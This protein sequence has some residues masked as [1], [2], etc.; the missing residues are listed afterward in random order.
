MTPYPSVDRKNR[1]TNRLVGHAIKNY[2]IHGIPVQ[3]CQEA[4]TAQQ[5]HHTYRCQYFGGQPQQCRT[6][7]ERLIVTART[8]YDT[9][10]PY[11]RIYAYIQLRATIRTIRQHCCCSGTNG[12][13]TTTAIQ[14]NE[15]PAWLHL[16]PTEHIILMIRI[17]KLHRNGTRPQ[18]LLELMP[19]LPAG[20]EHL[21]DIVPCR[22]RSERTGRDAG[23]VCVR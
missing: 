14:P 21:D 8:V 11:G 18:R 10:T 20:T 9:I 22:I 2:V 4:T 23:A 12:R 16:Q 7:R 6:M 1:N 3:I 15:R 13:H 17:D 5:Q 19:I